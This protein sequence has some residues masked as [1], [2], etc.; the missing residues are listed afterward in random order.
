MT[1]IEADT[2]ESDNQGQGQDPAPASPPA[3]ESAAPRMT[4]AERRAKLEQDKADSI[5]RAKREAAAQFEQEERDLEIDERGEQ[6]AVT[7]LARNSENVTISIE[8][9]LRVSALALRPAPAPIPV[10]PP[11]P[12]VVPPAPGPGQGPDAE[13]L[14]N[15]DVAEK[16]RQRKAKAKPAEESATTPTANATVKPARLPPPNKPVVAAVSPAAPSSTASFDAEVLAALKALGEGKF[17]ATKIKVSRSSTQRTD[18]LNRLLEPGKGRF[19]GQGQGH[20][21]VGRQVVRR[22]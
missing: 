1:D 7:Y 22:T 12:V 14:H 2:I 8:N 18:A 10:V 20:E 19:R 5:E 21:M 13:D 16:R 17:L 15:E 4:V 9:W 6:L 3:D 11:D